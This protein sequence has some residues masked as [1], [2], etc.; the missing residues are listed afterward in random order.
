MSLVPIIVT[1]AAGLAAIG[2]SIYFLVAAS[3][4]GRRTQGVFFLILGLVLL[5]VSGGLAARRLSP[6]STQPLVAT[7]RGPIQVRVMAALPVE[8]WVREAASQ[9]NQTNIK[10]AGPG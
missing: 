3:R 10:Q 8:P 9:F 5:A 7:P 6:G 4:S 1:L 2:V